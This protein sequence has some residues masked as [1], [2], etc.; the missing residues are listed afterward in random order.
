MIYVATRPEL[1]SSEL[2]H[3][4]VSSELY[5]HGIKGQRWGVRRYQNPDG[6]LTD[7]G[8]RRY[9]Y[10]SGRDSVMTENTKSYMKKGAKIGATI[11]GVLGTA[12]SIG[13]G[14]AVA[15][16]SP[17]MLP[18]HVATSVGAV[19]LDTILG[20]ARGATIGGIVGA[21]STHKGRQYIDRYDKGLDDFEAREA[22]RGN[23]KN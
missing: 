14:I 22:R 18:M 6:S 5:H 13:G 4:D 20:A 10:G 2:F 1:F 11:N 7:E 12:F 3:S 17:A 16:M 21:A 19:A 9:G 23:R 15:S 8:R